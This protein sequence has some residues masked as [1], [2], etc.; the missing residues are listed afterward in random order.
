MAIT[1]EQLRMARAA[2]KMTL[3]DLAARAGVDKGTLV[4][5]EAGNSAHPLTLKQVRQVLEAAGVLF[6]EPVDG[7]HRGAAALRW[8]ADLCGQAERG[9]GE[10][11]RRTAARS[12]RGRGMRTRSYLGISCTLRRSWDRG[13]ARLLARAA[14]RVGG[15]ASL[16]T[17]GVVARNGFMVRVADG[18]PAASTDQPGLVKEDRQ[19]GRSRPKNSYGARRSASPRFEGQSWS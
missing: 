1:G 3:R 16:D 7:E 9:A 17:V 5:I 10:D 8:D 12:M 19:H 13:D 11:V 14:H 4:R 2:L 15:D 18:R 6:I